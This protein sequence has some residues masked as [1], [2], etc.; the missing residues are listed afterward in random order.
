MYEQYLYFKFNLIRFISLMSSKDY[1]KRP[2]GMVCKKC[3]L[4]VSFYVGS[5]GRGKSCGGELGGLYE[6]FWEQVQ[7]PGA[8]KYLAGFYRLPQSAVIE[9]RDKTDTECVLATGLNV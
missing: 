9:K 7:P 5:G 4:G 3:H 6:Y 1:Y 2:S 8:Q